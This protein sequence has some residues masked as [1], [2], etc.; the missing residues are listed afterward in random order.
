MVNQMAGRS[1]AQGHITTFTALRSPDRQRHLGFP[2]TV[3]IRLISGN[4]LLHEPIHTQRVMP[5]ILCGK[6]WIHFSAR[7]IMQELNLGILMPS[8][9]RE[10]LN[11][12]APLT[13]YWCRRGKSVRV[14]KHTRS[15]A[16]DQTEEGKQLNTSKLV[17]TTS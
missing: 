4:C 10:S 13:S 2:R 1:P 15:N 11:F 12:N 17:L 7:W 3:L 16:F 5:L 6:K 9:K 8:A 14:L